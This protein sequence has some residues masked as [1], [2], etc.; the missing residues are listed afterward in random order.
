MPLNP[1]SNKL[2]GDLFGTF[3]NNKGSPLREYL[4]R[5]NQEEDLSSSSP[6]L[7]NK[8]LEPNETDPLIGVSLTSNDSLVWSPEGSALHSLVGL[9]IVLNKDSKV[10]PRQ[11]ANNITASTGGQ[12]N[13]V[14]EN[15]ILGCAIEIPETAELTVRRALANNPNVS[16]VEPNVSYVEKDRIVKLDPPPGKGPGSGG[17]DDG[18][19]SPLETTPWGITRVGGGSNYSGSGSAWII[20]TGIDLDH[21]DLNVDVTR[22][23]TKVSKGP[24]SKNADDGNGH[25][26]HVA[27][28]LAAINNDIGVIGVAAGASVVAVKVLDKRGSGSYSDVIA[29]VDHVAANAQPGDVANMSLGGG[30]NTTLNDAV[31]AAAAK[32]IVFSLAAGNNSNDASKYSPASTDDDGIYTVSAINRADIFADFSNYGNSPIDYAAPGV[33]VFS[34]WTQGGYN[35][36]SGTSMAAPHVAGLALLGGISTDGYALGD[37]DANPDPIASAV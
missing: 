35:T 14:Y 9:I 10:S 2:P 11:L 5:K 36:I 8:V 6:K 15:S 18:S 37:P 1:Y 31:K 17:G 32:G 7:E 4:E 16:Y 22:S 20:D 13:H 23:V 29:G 30:K 24:D 33:E 27:G 3:N 12:V 19:S 26:T 25:G 28:T 21:Q 34:T